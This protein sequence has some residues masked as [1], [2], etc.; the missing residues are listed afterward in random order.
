MKGSFAMHAYQVQSS[1]VQRRYASCAP[2]QTQLQIIELAVNEDANRLERAGCRVL[3][4]FA[5][6]HGGNKVMVGTQASFM[7]ASMSASSSHRQSGFGDRRGGR[8][9][10]RGGRGGGGGGSSGGGGGGGGGT[11]IFFFS[12]SASSVCCG[13]GDGGGASTNIS[14]CAGIALSL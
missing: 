14:S 13:L 5:A 12:S 4:F 9:G 7:A 8:L 11:T 2:P 6:R 1:V 10:G 3:V